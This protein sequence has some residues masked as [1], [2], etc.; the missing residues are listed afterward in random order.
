MLFNIYVKP[1]CE[2]FQYAKDTQLYPVVLVGPREVVETMNWCLET[3]SEQMRAHKLN[4][5]ISRNYV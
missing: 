4:G 1:L 2:A 3:V 5:N